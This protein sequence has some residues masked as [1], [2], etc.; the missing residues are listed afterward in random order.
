MTALYLPPPVPWRK[1]TGV[2]GWTRFGHPKDNG[3]GGLAVSYR[4]DQLLAISDL[5]YAEAPD[6]SGDR[7]WQYHVS[8]SRGWDST[9]RLLM[10]KERIDARPTNAEVAEVARAFCLDVWE[11]DNHTSGLARH[12]WLPVDPDRRVACQCKLDEQT[13]TEPDGYQWQKPR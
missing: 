12:L 9:G 4:K 6:G 5:V 13:L 10:Y 7:V 11:E 8:V 2:T 1:P 3:M